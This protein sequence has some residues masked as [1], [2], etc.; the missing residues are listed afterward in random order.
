MVNMLLPKPENFKYM[1]I[2]VKPRRVGISL[3]K[4]SMSHIALNPLFYRD[5]WVLITYFYLGVK[6]VYSLITLQPKFE[7]IVTFKFV[8]ISIVKKLLLIFLVGTMISFGQEK[9]KD[10]IIQGSIFK[11]PYNEVYQQPLYLEKALY[12]NVFSK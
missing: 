10:L 11:V 12:L 6:W 2:Y 9:N 8:N 1:K 7:L 5:S 3:P 4:N